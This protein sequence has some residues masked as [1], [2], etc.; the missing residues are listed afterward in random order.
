MIVTFGSGDTAAKSP[1][2]RFTALRVIWNLG[3]RYYNIMLPGATNVD[4]DVEG[5]S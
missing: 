5:F 4:H 3:F 1:Q 2:F